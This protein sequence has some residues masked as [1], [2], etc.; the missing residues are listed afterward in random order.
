MNPYRNTP[1]P[2]NRAHGVKPRFPRLPQHRQHQQHHQHQRPRPR[3][4]NPDEHLWTPHRAP[5]LNHQHQQLHQQ[6]QQNPQHPQHHPNH[7]ADADLNHLSSNDLEYKLVCVAKEAMPPPPRR[8][9]KLVSD[10]T[11][12]LY[13]RDL[14]VLCEAVRARYDQATGRLN[15]NC[16]LKDW[17]LGENGIRLFI[18]TSPHMAL[19]V[20]CIRNIFTGTQLLSI[21]SVDLSWN[22]IRSLDGVRAVM[23]LFP[24]LA[25]LSLVMNRLES[26]DELKKIGHDGLRKL[27]LNNN[28]IC[29]ATTG[30]RYMAEVRSA[31]PKLKELDEISLSKPKAICP[32]RVS[33]RDL[34]TDL[35]DVE[36]VDSDEGV[37]LNTSD[38]EDCATTQGSKWVTVDPEATGMVYNTED[39]IIYI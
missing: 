25:T 24:N 35:D 39:L 27:L 30:S 1:H 22:C 13:L 19:L 11:T 29:D 8:G 28:Q 14:F 21:E 37:G 9:K 26:L 20:E 12:K 36:L 3:Y 7:K 38:E 23:D 10:T 6:L 31:F 17:M 33:R 4:D 34:C 32:R 18:N 16:L 15:L 2:Y 5:K